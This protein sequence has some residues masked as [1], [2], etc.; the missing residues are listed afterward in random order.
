MPRLVPLA[1]IM[2]LFPFLGCGD[3][4]DTTK[5]DPTGGWADSVSQWVHA[6]QATAV[7]NREACLY[8]TPEAVDST[9]LGDSIRVAIAP[10]PAEPDTLPPLDELPAAFETA[11][12][13]GRK[14]FPPL[15]RFYAYD[16]TGQSFTEFSPEGESV[17]VVAMCVTGRYGDE[18]ALERALLAR[19]DPANPEALQYLEPEDPPAECQLTCEVPGGQEA[20]QRAASPLDR[21]L[22]GT[23]LTAT[24]AFAVQCT[25]CFQKGIGGGSAGNSPFA[26]VD[27]VPDGGDSPEQQVD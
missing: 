15:Y 14:V 26:A 23:P 17:V 1:A 6:G 7:T 3:R 18:D 21:W 5:T 19:P 11:V 20:A 12:G 25:T 22:T 24:P 16:A 4:P 13:E 2:F 10:A 9:L 27:T 8:I